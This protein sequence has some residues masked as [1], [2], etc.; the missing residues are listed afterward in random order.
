MAICPSCLTKYEGDVITCAKDGVAL[1]PEETFAA[2]DKDLVPGDLVGEYKIEEKIGEG[3]FGAVYRAVHPVIGKHAA[4]KVLGRQFSANATMV[5]RFISEARAV[6]QIRHRNIVDIFSFGA[7][8]DGRQYYIMELLEGM[9]F[10]R[11]LDQQKRLTLAQALP[12]LRGIARALDAAHAKGI[13]HRDLKPENV[14]LVFDEDRR[15]EPKLLDFGLVKLMAEASGSGSGN[16]RTK[17][18]TPMGTPYYMSPEQCR[19]LEVDRRTDVYAFGALIFQV[20]TG[21][22]PFNGDSSMDV[23]VKHMTHV[24]PAASE[25]CLDVSPAVDPIIAK[26]MA[27]EPA[28]RPSSLGE[29]IDRLVT[30]QGDIPL[31]EAAT[32]PHAANLMSPFHAS[33]RRLETVPTVIDDGKSQP[34][35]AQVRI[36]AAG[37]SLLGS[38]SD[39]PASAPVKPR[40]LLPFIAAGGLAAVVA[41]AIALSLNGGAK[42]A[43]STPASGGAG[44]V[45][46]PPQAKA[47]QSAAQPVG[48]TAQ[49]PA[50]E[51]VKIRI[52][53]APAGAMVS[54]DGKELGAAPGPFTMKN[55]V[56]TKL[57][58]TAKG[59]KTK[60][61]TVKASPDLVVSVSLERLLNVTGMPKGGAGAAPGKGK[62]IHSDLEGF[63]SNSK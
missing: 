39:V 22:V 25:R 18:G 56:E 60:E 44:V 45:Q 49:A 43:A 58:V 26:M 63:D 40:R 11:Y 10:D 24:P 59:Y 38:E 23:L 36:A 48:S 30:A 50:A 41:V 1:V 33:H 3:G 27:K 52:D 17:T 15:V 21:E 32:I 61:L 62:V 47:A 12:I 8:P 57:V 7:L 55:G 28:D 54:A 46:E 20:L 29:C 2:V 37:Q 51:D 53:G 35:S 4:V 19:G 14:F 16:H 34:G 5:S 31:G 42:P 13:L 9:P 6:N